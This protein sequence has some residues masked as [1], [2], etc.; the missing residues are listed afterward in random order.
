M[1]VCVCE[2]ELW[3]GALNGTRGS[4]KGSECFLSLPVVQP[5]RNLK[6]SGTRLGINFSNVIEGLILQSATSK[7]V[8]INL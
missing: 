3:E 6:S 4:R 7:H 2:G 1:C 8:V 5:D